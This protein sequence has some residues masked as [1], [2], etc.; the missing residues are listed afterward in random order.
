MTSVFVCLFVFMALPMVFGSSQA[1][2]QILAAAMS[3]TTTVATL[4]TLIYCSRPG[5][6]SAP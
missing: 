6:E 4:H 2:D 1:R 3:Y 5:I